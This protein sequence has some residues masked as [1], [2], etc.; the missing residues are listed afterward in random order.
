MVAVHPPRDQTL[1]DPGQWP[2]PS[3]AAVLD[4]YYH[5]IRDGSGA[6][7]RSSGPGVKREGGATFCFTLQ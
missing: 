4:A 6:E 1:Q 5:F 2:V 7:A 3:Y